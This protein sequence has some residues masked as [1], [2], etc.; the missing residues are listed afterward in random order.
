M[1]AF[2][3]PDKS[4]HSFS[5]CLDFSLRQH[6][7]T[8]TSHRMMLSGFSIRLK[9]RYMT[10]TIWARVHM[11][12]HRAALTNI[13]HGAKSEPANTTL[14]PLIVDC[15][16]VLRLSYCFHTLYYYLLASARRILYIPIRHII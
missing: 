6:V 10:E 4:N 16:L 8:I 12:M 13:V 2:Q 9:A 3:V 1:E 7:P 11:L 15:W 14:L 5:S